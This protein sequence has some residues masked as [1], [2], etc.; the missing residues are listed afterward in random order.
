MNIFSSSVQS[1]LAINQFT[2]HISKSLPNESTHLKDLRFIHMVFN[3]FC[4]VLA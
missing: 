3:M 1:H 2:S 4:V